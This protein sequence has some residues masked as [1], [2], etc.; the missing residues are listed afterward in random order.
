MSNCIH[1]PSIRDPPNDDQ[2]N[3]RLFLHDVYEYTKDGS[4]EDHTRAYVHPKRWG[5]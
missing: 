3:N 4:T 5:C 1:V 2:K